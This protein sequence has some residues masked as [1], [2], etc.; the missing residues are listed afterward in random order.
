MSKIHGNK[1]YVD[2]AG[3]ELKVRQW[4]MDVT[5]PASDTTAMG[6]TS[7][8]KQGGAPIQRTLSF[9]FQL[10]DTDTAQAALTVGATV[11]CG[12]Y[13]NGNGSGEDY[14][15]GNAYVESISHPQNMND[16]V[17][18][19]ANCIGTGDWTVETVA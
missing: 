14:H 9:V 12:L 11:A 10:M 19:T 4:S 2:I 6:D 13:A 3:S 17:E 15:S 7:E 16:M 18:I 1:G 8:S 5:A